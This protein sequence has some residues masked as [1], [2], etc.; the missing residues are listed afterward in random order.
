MPPLQA[1]QEAYTEELTD[2]K[3]KYAAWKE[4]LFLGLQGLNK[5]FNPQDQKPVRLLRDVREDRRRQEKGQT[6]AGLQQQEDWRVKNE[7]GNAQIEN[8]R[9]KPIFDQQRLDLQKTKV[10]ND[11]LM[12]QA[13]YDRL[14]KAEEN[15]NARSGNQTKIQEVDGYLFRAYPNDPSKAMEP[16]IDPRTGKQAFNPANISQEITFDDGTKAWAKGGQIVSGKFA[17][18][19]QAKQINAANTR[20]EDQQQFTASQNT[21][22]QRF[23][24]QMQED[25]QKFG[26]TEAIKRATD[27]F[28]RVYMKENGGEVPSQSDIDAFLSGTQMQATGEAIPQP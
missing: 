4:A 2:P 16:I 18:E 22:Q 26:E 13:T 25:R 15:R 1:A 6:L 3:K 23:A 11:F 28:K 10:E 27:A 17:G 20:Q 21:I 5:V 7:L 12:K 24:K 19:R 8:T 9:M 14:I